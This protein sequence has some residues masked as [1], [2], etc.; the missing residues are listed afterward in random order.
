MS[1]A[2]DDYDVDDDP[3][4][5]EDDDEYPDDWYDDEPTVC[6]PTFDDELTDDQVAELYA[7]TNPLAGYPCPVYRRHK[8]FAVGRP[9]V[10]VLP[11]L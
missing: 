9:M 4:A 11:S 10:D 5:V 1:T 2:P 3:Y 7:P 6:E 8:P